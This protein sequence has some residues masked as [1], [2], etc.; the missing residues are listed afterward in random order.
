[1]FVPPSHGQRVAVVAVLVVPLIVVVVLS[2][3]AWITWPF[4]PTERREAVLQ[5]LDRLILWIKVLA[6]IAGVTPDLGVQQQPLPESTAT[7]LST[8]RKPISP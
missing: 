7:P 5:F 2:A 4:L 6:G 8:R 3:P 1:M